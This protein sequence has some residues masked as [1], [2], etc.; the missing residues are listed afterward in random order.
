MRIQANFINTKQIAI[1][2]YNYYI[3]RHTYYPVSRLTKYYRN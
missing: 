2:T 3:M 1:L